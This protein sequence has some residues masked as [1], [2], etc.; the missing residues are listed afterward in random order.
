MIYLL[1][2]STP[3]S[4][5]KSPAATQSSIRPISISSSTSMADSIPVIQSV[6]SLAGAGEPPAR[7][8]MLP[9]QPIPA[10]QLPAT[11]IQPTTIQQQQAPPPPPPPQVITRTTSETMVKFPDPPAMKNKSVGCKPFMAT[12]GVSCRPH[13]CHKGT[14]TDLP[15]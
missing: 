12:K 9:T 10:T 14:Q 1:F 8:D 2:S 13:P 3:K 11:T 4:S 5:L 7:P 6:S 15:R